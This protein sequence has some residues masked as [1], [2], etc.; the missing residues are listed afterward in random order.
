MRVRDFLG[1]VGRAGLPGAF[2]C[3][4]LFLWPL[5][6]SA[7]LGPLR[8]EVA[9]FLFLCLPAFF[10][11]CSLYAPPLSRA[12]SG[13][14]ARVPWAL[15][16]CFPF[17]PPRLVLFFL[18]APVV[19]GFLGFPTPGAQG[20]GAVCCLFCWSPASRLFVRSRCICVFRLAAGCSLVVA[21]PPPPF[22]VSRFSSLPLSAPP[23]PPPPLFFCCL[24]LACLLG[25]RRRFSPS[26]SPPPPSSCFV[27]LRLLCSPCALRAFVFPAWP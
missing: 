5:C 23:P 24:A 18:C 20:L 9:P 8:A 14:R 13:F 6:F 10:L 1:R 12:F 22:F 3:A 17:L 21:A 27:G 7:L 11:R 19:S 16:L 15:A 26:A 2:R 4:S 25:A